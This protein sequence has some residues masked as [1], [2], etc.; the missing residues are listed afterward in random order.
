MHRYLNKIIIKLWIFLGLNIV[1]NLYDNVISSTNYV[2]K[3]VVIW[4][5]T[6]WMILSLTCH[7]TQQ[8]SDD[9]IFYIT[10]ERS[11]VFT[12]YQT[13]HVMY[14]PCLSGRKI[15]CNDLLEDIWLMGAT[16]SSDLW[17]R[18]HRGQGHT[19]WSAFSASLL[20]QRILWTCLGETQ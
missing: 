12:Q 16:L 11:Q 5:Q 3:G 4:M 10:P 15:L 17:S 14:C 2:T 19:R 13:L 8:E 20:S 1:W 6:C 9:S 18:W 7:R